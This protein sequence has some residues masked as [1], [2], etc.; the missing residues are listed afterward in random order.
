MEFNEMFSNDIPLGLK[1]ITTSV[2]KVDRDIVRDCVVTQEML[3]FIQNECKSLELQ[4][5][6][7]NCHSS[8]EASVHEMFL[9]FTNASTIVPHTHLDK[10]ESFFILKGKVG[11]AILDSNKPLIKRIVILDA[12]NGPVYTC[13]K[14]GLC[15]LVLS[16]SPVSLVHEITSGPFVKD[17]AV[18]PQWALD[19]ILGSA[20][21]SKLKQEM[22]NC[23]GSFRSK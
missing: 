5:C 21:I 8:D 13:V 4:R 9:A 19:P 11:I 15:H 23:H 3:C 16:L 20:N 22:T 6:R 17:A 10:S 2:Y 1:K 7:I 14:A 18:I 12:L